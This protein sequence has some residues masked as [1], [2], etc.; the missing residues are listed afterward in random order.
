[1]EMVQ[2]MLLQSNAQLHLRGHA[3]KL[4]AHT[5]CFTLSNSLEGGETPNSIFYESRVEDGQPECNWYQF[6]CYSVIH[7]GKQLVKDGKLSNLGIESIYVGVDTY[8][9]GKCHLV[10]AQG[11]IYRGVDVVCDEKYF[12]YVQFPATADDPFTPAAQHPDFRGNQG[13]NKQKVR[14]KSDQILIDYAED[15]DDA[16]EPVASRTRSRTKVELAAVTNGPPVPVSPL[17]S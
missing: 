10:Y 3:A 2:C 16:T 7:R 9:K 12:P 17:K 11:R 6:G 1:M 15:N 14:F 8:E 4:A 13:A 5:R